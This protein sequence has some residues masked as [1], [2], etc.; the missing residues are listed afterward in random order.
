MAT[1]P[2][3]ITP[4]ARM[5]GRYRLLRARLARLLREL[6]VH[7]TDTA[8]DLI[9]A[10]AARLG[11]QITVGVHPFR[12]PGF[13]GATIATDDGYAILVQAATSREHQTHITMH[14]I[15]HILLGTTDAAARALFEGTHRTGDY[16][17]PEER[18]AEFVARTISAWTRIDHD[19]AMPAQPDEATARIARSLEDRMTWV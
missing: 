5:P 1:T 19:A 16:S 3:L 13:F 8:E 18:D 15:A 9:A 7:P 2:L 14:E 12:V 10:L 6:G 17:D 4:A 11:V